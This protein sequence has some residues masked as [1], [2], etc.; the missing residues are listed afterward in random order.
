MRVFEWIDQIFYT[1]DDAIM[2]LINLLTQILN[3]LRIEGEVD[4]PS[5]NGQPAFATVSIDSY[6]VHR[7]NPYETVAV[8]NRSHCDCNTCSTLCEMRYLEVI[9]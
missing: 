7:C 5:G 9:V 2:L 1:S 4:N 8:A 3:R 6:I